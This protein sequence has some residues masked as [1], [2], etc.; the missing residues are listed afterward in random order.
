[1]VF[2]NFSANINLN[3]PLYS[4]SVTGKTVPT[5]ALK[6]GSRYIVYRE[7]RFLYKKL[8]NCFLQCYKDFLDIRGQA[9][10]QL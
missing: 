1:M 3:G 4:L 9:V 5:C 2:S 6:V 8:N 10:H 7:K